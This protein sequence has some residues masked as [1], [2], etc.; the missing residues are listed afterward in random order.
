M[1][2]EKMDAEKLLKNKNKIIDALLDYYR[3]TVWPNCEGCSTEFSLNFL[4]EVIVQGAAL[5]LCGVMGAC[6]E[7]ALDEQVAKNYASRVAMV[8]DE[9]IQ[10]VMAVRREAAGK[11]EGE[12]NEV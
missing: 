8:L 10:Q 7:K 9:T 12:K 5:G 6:S 3:N 2:L 11:E 1:K 4:S